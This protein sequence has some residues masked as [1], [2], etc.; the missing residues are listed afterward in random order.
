MYCAPVSTRHKYVPSGL[1][2]EV[3]LRQANLILYEVRSCSPSLSFEQCEAAVIVPFSF[4]GTSLT[5][6]VL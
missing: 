5:D 6:V 1:D 4:V 3:D 2:F